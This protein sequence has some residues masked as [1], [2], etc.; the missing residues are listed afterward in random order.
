MLAV[1]SDGDMHDKPAAQRLITTLHRN[2][3]AVLWLR[4]ADLSGHTF[5]DTTTIMV[6]DPIDAVRHLADAAISA[7][8]TA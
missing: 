4:P 5:T 6:A 8:T 3:C 1:I 2:G 7:L